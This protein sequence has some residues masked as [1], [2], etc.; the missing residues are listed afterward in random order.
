M[1]LKERLETE[2]K[3]YQKI[4]QELSA[5]DKRKSELMTAGVEIQGKI[6][7]L[8]ELIIAEDKPKE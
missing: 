7:L 4:R 3:N 6:N 2:Q 1:N 8:N 5:I